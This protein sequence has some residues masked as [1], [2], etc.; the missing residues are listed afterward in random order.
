MVREGEGCS[1]LLEWWSAH[2]QRQEAQ[3]SAWVCLRPG[4][5]QGHGNKVFSSFPPNLV[6]SNLGSGS[7]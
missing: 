3:C 2:A 6:F 4:R 7:L 5:R 1:G